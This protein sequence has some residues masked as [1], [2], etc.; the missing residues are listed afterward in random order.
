MNHVFFFFKIGIGFSFSYYIFS[1]VHILLPTSC[2]LCHHPNLI[3]HI[4]WFRYANH[5]LLQFDDMWLALDIFILKK[6]VNALKY[7]TRSSQTREPLSSKWPAV[8]SHS[9]YCREEGGSKRSPSHIA[10]LSKIPTCQEQHKETDTI[11]FINC[12]IFVFS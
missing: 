6:M 5:L 2:N 10:L 12:C 3:S 9:I 11:S 1:R 4:L 7:W 8:C